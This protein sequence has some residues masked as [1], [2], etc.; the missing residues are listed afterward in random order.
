[1]SA[2]MAARAATSGSTPQRIG[3]GAP[4]DCS[5]Q[6]DPNTMLAL[7]HDDDEDR[8]FDGNLR[9]QG[10]SFQEKQRHRQEQLKKFKPGEPC[11]VCGDTASGIH[12]NAC[13]CNGCKTFFR[14]VIIE[15]RTYSCKRDGDCPIDK[16]M[17]CSCRHCRFKK[18]LKVGMDC[19]EL[20]LERS[21]KR[22]AVERPHPHAIADDV[23]DPLIISLIEKEKKFLM[24]LTST[25]TPIYSN[26]AE[27]L[28]SPHVFANL[29]R[30]EASQM[31]AK[32]SYNFSYWR[33]KILSIII[34]W[35]KSFEKFN[36]LSRADQEVLIVHMSF[37]NLVLS[38]AYHTPERYSD[39]IVFPDGLSGFR[40]LN[41]NMIK[42]KSGLIPTVVAVINNILV[43]IRKMQMTEIE[44]VLLQAIIL[45][46]PEC[47]SLSAQGQEIVT[48][49][50]Q[51]LL[52]SLRAHLS[53]SM[54][55]YESAY[56]FAAILL[57]ISACHKVAA[58]KRETLCTIEMFNLMS[59]HPLTMEISKKYPEV[60]FF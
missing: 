40:N 13:V 41:T 53:A 52:S 34:E 4:F 26:L 45:F 35:A 42:E 30:Y 21:R 27:A 7:K 12:Y 46:D 43:P 49:T 22:K 32:D 3:T 58:F 28:G 11:V 5:H 44:Y 57:R 56:R 39:R 20:N 55:R 23:K 38:E 18:C 33:S 29:S 47:L 59:P 31:S 50:R 60:S 10:V 8:C 6:L 2:S 25:I 51:G 17:R 15:N 24:L 54:S 37:S 48:E 16:D 14:R 19:V 1:M 36:M 9:T